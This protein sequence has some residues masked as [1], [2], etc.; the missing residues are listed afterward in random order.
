MQTILTFLQKQ[1]ALK[2]WPTVQSLPFQLGFHGAIGEHDIYQEMTKK[3]F[4]LNF[5]L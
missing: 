2:R 3:L 5:Q 1:A 4:G